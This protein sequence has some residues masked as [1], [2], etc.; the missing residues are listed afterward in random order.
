MDGEEVARQRARLLTEAANPFRKL[1]LW[2][3]L[4]FGAS[5]VIGFFVAFFRVLAGRELQS[6]LINLAVQSGVIAL[7]VILWRFEAQRESEMVERYLKR[8]DRRQR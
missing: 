4:A 7:M 1:R 6:S 5:G 2:L 3:Y 8:R